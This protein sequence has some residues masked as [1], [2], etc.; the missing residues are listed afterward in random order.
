MFHYAKCGCN[1]KQVNA[2]HKCDH[3]FMFSSTTRPQQSVEKRCAQ[4]VKPTIFIIFEIR[5]KKQSTPRCCTT[6]KFSDLRTKKPHRV[7]NVW[8]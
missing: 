8:T 4:S 5:V 6:L 1:K 7:D 2:Q 3:G